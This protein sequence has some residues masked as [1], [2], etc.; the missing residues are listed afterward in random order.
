MRSHSK[1][2]K[3]DFCQ[4]LNGA[5]AAKAE[6]MSVLALQVGNDPMT[7]DAIG[8]LVAV[9][10]CIEEAAQGEGGGRSPATSWEYFRHR[11]DS[12]IRGSCLVSEAL[13]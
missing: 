7:V 6:G 9:F 11:F 5:R 1:L 4:Q 10:G 2:W 12:S 3:R 13:S 8:Q